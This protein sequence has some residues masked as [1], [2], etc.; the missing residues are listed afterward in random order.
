MS[1]VFM[2]SYGPLPIKSVLRRA[3]ARFPSDHAPSVNGRVGAYGPHFIS[4]RGSIPFFGVRKQGRWK[5][6]FRGGKGYQTPIST[7]GGENFLV[8]LRSSGCVVA[9]YLLPFF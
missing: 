8:V 9:L 1:R 4:I 6:V 5:M 2:S 7:F 3:D